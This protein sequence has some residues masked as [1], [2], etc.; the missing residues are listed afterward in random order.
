MK[1]RITITLDNDIL[2]WIDSK[3]KER[4]FASRSH[5]FEFLIREDS[6]EEKQADEDT[7]YYYF[8]RRTS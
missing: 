5:G 7:H 4:V 8:G 6:V 1:E 3:V 2:E